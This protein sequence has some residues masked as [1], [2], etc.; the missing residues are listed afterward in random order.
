MWNAIAV[1]RHARLA[2]P[3][4]RNMAGAAHARAGCCG[5]VCFPAHQV[6]LTSMNTRATS[7]RHGQADQPR[8]R[9][10]ASASPTADAGD[11]RTR[12]STDCG[13]D[14]GDGRNSG[15]SAWPV[16]C[17]RRGAQSPLPGCRWDGASQR[18][19]AGQR[20][21]VAVIERFTVNTLQV[22]AAARR[23]GRAS[24]RRMR[25]ATGFD[26]PRSSTHHTLT[27]RV[28]LRCLKGSSGWWPGPCNRSHVACAR[29]TARPF[30]LFAC[31]AVG[32]RGRRH[33]RRP[34]NM[35]KRLRTRARSARR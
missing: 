24:P 10:G 22:V 21:A 30:H 19:R 3:T 14:Q 32:Q 17:L 15:E 6:H 5:R 9:F 12:I 28:S 23:S 2:R 31:G 4:G 16:V 29:R 27:R 33:P 26:S 25:R 35:R 13:A 20:L 18:Q 1:C 11:R 7:R 34:L 8:S